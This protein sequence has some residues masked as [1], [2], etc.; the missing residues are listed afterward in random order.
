[1]LN[2]CNFRIYEHFGSWNF[3]LQAHGA[4]WKN[5]TYTYTKNKKRTVKTKE[6]VLCA[7]T[8]QNFVRMHRW[9]HP[10]IGSCKLKIPKDANN[11]WVQ[12]IAKKKEHTTPVCGWNWCRCL[13]RWAIID[14]HIAIIAQDL[15]V[16]S[17]ILVT[18]HTVTHWL[19]PVSVR[20][21]PDR[22]RPMGG[23]DRILEF[24]I[25]KRDSVLSLFWF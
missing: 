10:H 17:K 12:I 18:P 4:L 25:L 11:F 14:A 16:R 13:L 21:A 22:F 3:A 1:M 5:T 20:F 6:T 23:G 8:I 7:L 19:P 15:E 9:R 2:S 24:T